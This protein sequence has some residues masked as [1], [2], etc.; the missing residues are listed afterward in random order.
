[1]RRISIIFAFI[2][3]TW[4]LLNGAPL[5]PDSLWRDFQS[6]EGKDWRASF[7]GSGL[8]R[9]L[10]ATSARSAVRKADPQALIETYYGL[11]GAE[12][13]ED[14]RFE[15]KVIHESGIEYVYRQIISG[16]PVEGAQVHLH[17]DGNAQLIAATSTVSPGIQVRSSKISAAPIAQARALRLFGGRAT[18]GRASLVLIPSG[19]FAKPA[20]KIAVDPF[21]INEGSRLMY[22]DAEDP[23]VVLRIHNTFAYA[24]GRGSVF[25]ENPVITP[26]M[27]TET[28]QYMDATTSLSGKFVKTYNANFEQFSPSS[29]S[30]ADFSAYTTASDT[31]RQ[32]NYPI[33][34][35]RFTEAMA[36][37]H[38]NRVHDQWKR[39]GFNRLNKRMPV[40]VNIMS[41]SG[42]FGYDNAFYR[43]SERYPTGLVV[44]GAGNRLENLG[45]DADVY[46]HEY[47]HAVLDH[48]KPEF[49]ESIENNYSGAFHEGFGD[50]SA[51]AITG[52]SKLAEYALRLK[53]NRKFIG[54]DL[55]NNNR[56]PNNVI[57][58]AFRQS[59]SHHTGLIFGGAW[60]DLQKRIGLEQAQRVLYKGVQMLPQEMNFFDVRDSMLTVDQNQN[61]G[62]N[63]SAINDSFAE[64]GI[65]GPDPGQPGTV[66]VKALKTAELRLPSAKFV[67]KTK[68]KKGDFIVLFAN[69]TGT[70]L[71]PGYNLIPIRFEFN[72]PDG[73]LIDAYAWYGEVLNGNNNG[74][75][76]AY[77]GEIF[78]YPQT[79]SGTYTITLQSRLGGTSIL[80]EVKTVSFQVV[81]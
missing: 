16:L 57:Y 56:Y 63:V 37:F 26:S 74:I 30:A 10:Y 23:R 46:Y 80:T 64:H 43:R 15:R 6:K 11:F 2:F 65:T 32:F 40:F 76:G 20:W 75:R 47:G 42:D 9:T 55:E 17:M 38:I 34:D 13:A 79:K 54:R 28:F 68:F 33:T 51:S 5:K 29:S 18:A 58:P 8:L 31:A 66:T 1:M 77:Q 69:Y 61:A 7:R 50:V 72:G 39:F 70:G 60:W 24:E 35:A 52:N 21:E 25:A 12:H 3:T 36:Y 67:M 49:F 62:Q 45:H 53:S 44:M 4:T 81:D 71:T 19:K 22:V 59:E 73:G 14:L 27:S 78:T 48:A 41:R